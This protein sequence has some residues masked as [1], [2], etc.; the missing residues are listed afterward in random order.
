MLQRLIAFIRNFSKDEE[1]SAELTSKAEN[2]QAEATPKRSFMDRRSGEDQ[3]ARYD[4]NYFDDNGVERRKGRE[5]RGI[6][7]QRKYWKRA[8]EWSS[9]FVGKGAAKSKEEDTED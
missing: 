8:S 1:N 6:V 3:R 5:R 2:G 7:E 9:V 4:L